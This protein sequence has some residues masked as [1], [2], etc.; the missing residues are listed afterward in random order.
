MVNV[1]KHAVLVAI[2][3]DIGNVLELFA[4]EVEKQNHVPVMK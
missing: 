3:L 4:E 2:K 1:P